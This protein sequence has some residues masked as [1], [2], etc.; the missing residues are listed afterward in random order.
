MPLSPDQTAALAAFHKFLD[1]SEEPVFLLRGYAG[2]GKTTLLKTLLAELT[3]PAVLLAPTGRAARVMTRQT[4]REATTIHRGIY[5]FEKLRRLEETEDNTGKDDAHKSFK[6]HFDLANN[7]A[8]KGTVFVVDE[9]SMIGDKYS[10][11][12]FFQLGSGRLL[13]DLLQYVQPSVHNGYKI[14][15][16]GDRAQLAP[17]G[18]PESRALNEQWLCERLGIVGALPGRELTEVMRQQADSGIL[19]NATAVRECLR[20]SDFNRLRLTRAADVQDVPTGEIL[21]TY[22]G[23]GGG[24]QAGDKTV[25]VTYSNNLARQYNEQVRAHFFPGQ[26]SVAVDDW[27]I[28]AQNNYLNPEE[29]IYN[30]EFA[31]VLEVGESY[32]I[33]RKVSIAVTD[34]KT[35]E[36]KRTDV[37][38]PLRWRR[39][40]LRLTRPDG[41]QYEAERLLLESF[42]TSIDG[43]LRPEATR[44]LY[45]DAVIRWREKTGHDHK[46]PEFSD[47][48]KNDPQF[49][50]LRVKYGYAITCHKA[51]G[52]T[53][54]TAFVDFQG[55]GGQRHAE[56]FR[57]VYTAITRAAKQLYLLNP[58]DFVPWGEMRV[59]DP[60]GVPPAPGGIALWPEVLRAQTALFDPLDELESRLGIASRPVA[61]VQQFRR[62][63]GQL[64]EMGV[65]V[66]DVSD[67]QHALR[68][69]LR[70]GEERGEVL[71][72]YKND[73][74]F[75]KAVA[76]GKAN[77]LAQEA[78]TRLNE[79][80]PAGIA[81]VPATFADDA[82][83]ALAGF[84]EQFAEAATEAG[85]MILIVQHH[86]NLERYLLQDATGRAVLNLDYDGKGRMTGA[87]ITQHDSQSLL[88]RVQTILQNLD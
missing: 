55:Y 7:Q 80:L 77:A 3:R 10:E 43:Q 14:L 49:Q 67:Q 17:V 70:R 79:P 20:T 65:N 27:L 83:P 25:I 1:S 88:H 4:G 86:K 34:K 82:P 37:Y 78:T 9:A 62:V 35:L 64:G 32:G 6:Y 19:R 40:R 21:A 74:P 52:G 48:L 47:F 45:I 56:Y 54:D 36:K 76:Q 60:L 15:L 33:S 73:V 85:I 50:A 72:Y 42:L 81:V 46:H 2:T 23:A 12:E 66:E 63:A 39:V 11:S 75:S 5:N 38:V 29:A 18:D 53:W 57:W 61:Q 44:A 24:P 69:L 68:Y 51:Q 30:G 58:P 41:S 8:T 71:A 16:V 26:T 84:Y 13:S 59:F 28:I 87:R 22:L 31:T